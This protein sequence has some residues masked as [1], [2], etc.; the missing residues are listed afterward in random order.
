MKRLI[1]LLTAILATAAD[2]QVYKCK[3]E[4]R[5]VYQ[6]MPCERPEQS[7]RIEERMTVVEPYPQRAARPPSR[8]AAAPQAETAA[9]VADSEHPSCQPLRDRIRSIDV[10]ARHRSTQRLKEQRWATKQK[11]AE[12]GCSEMGPR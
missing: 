3:I 6:E 2:A 11:L 8:T 4:E 10:S 12:L 1:P 5:T 7:H 9:P